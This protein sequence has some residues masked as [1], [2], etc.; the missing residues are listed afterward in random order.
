MKSSKNKL[1]NNKKDLADSKVIKTYKLIEFFDK[2]I[3]PQER[4]YYW[5]SGNMM[6]DETHEEH[7]DYLIRQSYVSV[8]PLKLDRTDQINKSFFKNDKTYV[9][10]YN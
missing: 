3:D 9:S 7:D 8:T 10:F 4:D 5:L 1:F 6:T 2:R